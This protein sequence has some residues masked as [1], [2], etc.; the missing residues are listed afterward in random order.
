MRCVSPDGQEFNFENQ[1][2]GVL[3]GGVLAVARSQ[4]VVPRER[5]ARTT[6]LVRTQ[7]VDDL[8]QYI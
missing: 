1:K 8:A 7:V 4:F 3:C 5:E 6:L 2:R